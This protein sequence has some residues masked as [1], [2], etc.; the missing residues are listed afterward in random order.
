MLGQS[1]QDASTRSSGTNSAPTV[2]SVQLT[3]ERPLPGRVVE[4]R[5]IVEDED[6]DRPRIQYRW[7]SA[8]GTL[9]GEGPS[10]DTTGLSSGERI[11]VIVV[12]T[13]GQEESAEFS[14]SLRLAEAAAQVAVVAIDASEGTSP[15]ATLNAYFESTGGGASDFDAEYEWQVN[16]E[17][18]STEDE[19]ETAAYSPG[20]VI[21]LRAR[22]GGGDARASRFVR[23]APVV[24]SR[25]DMPEILSEPLA[26]IE[27]GVFRYQLR[28]KSPSPDAELTFELLKGPQGM[29]VDAESG[30]VEWRPA[31]AQRGRFEIELAVTDQW[32][33]GVAQSFAIEAAGA[34]APP[35][36]RR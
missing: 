17:T 30:L 14:R 34:A 32:G 22:L 11:A 13:D 15:G 25:G 19:L 2:E 18:V 5:A 6:G 7:E 29:T 27:G 16:G 20:D 9:L 8:D 35:A 28:A 23:S 31:E 21:I 36:S 24:L 4:A 26:G 1:T 3:P 12:A 10:F 33:S